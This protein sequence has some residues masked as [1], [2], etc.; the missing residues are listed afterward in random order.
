[1]EGHRSRGRPRK[2]WID[3]VKEIMEDDIHRLIE[4]AQNRDKWRKAIMVATDD[5]NRSN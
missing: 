4:L 1:M 3:N 5:R 2:Q